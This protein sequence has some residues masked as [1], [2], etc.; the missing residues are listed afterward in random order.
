MRLP[1]RMTIAALNHSQLNCDW[2][3]SKLFEFEMCMGLRFVTYACRRLTRTRVPR[4]WTTCAFAP[5]V[6]SKILQWN[7]QILCVHISPKQEFPLFV[8][9]NYWVIMLELFLIDEFF[10]FMSL[11]VVRRYFRC[12]ST[13]LILHWKIYWFDGIFN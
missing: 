12:D 3:S 13:F 2:L 8:T 9:R 10:C 4:T 6:Y 11:M 7:G 1:S 5:T